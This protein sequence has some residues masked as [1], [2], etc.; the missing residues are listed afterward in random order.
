[1]RQDALAGLC[2]VAQCRHRD[3]G[4]SR[5]SVHAEIDSGDGE[6]GGERTLSMRAGL[7]HSGGR[8]RESGMP[9]WRYVANRGL[10]LVENKLLGTKVSEF[11]TGCRAFS[12]AL[13][14]RLPLAASSDDFVFGC[15]G[16]GGRPQAGQTGPDALTAVPGRSMSARRKP[17]HKRAAAQVSS[18]GVPRVAA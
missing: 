6:P 18:R 2:T 10:T 8:A 13:L 15:L 7:A 14:E 4:S 11:H 16:D 17:T 1:M 3:H 5:L 12:R 9:L